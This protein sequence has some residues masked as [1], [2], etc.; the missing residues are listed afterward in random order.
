MM[1]SKRARNYRRFTQF[2]RPR[3]CGPQKRRLGSLPSDESKQA[4]ISAAAA[5]NIREVL[6][7]A[8]KVASMPDREA[9][10]RYHEL[11]DKQIGEPLAAAERFELERIEARL[12]AGDR[13]PV[14]EARDREWEADRTRLLDSIDLLLTSLKR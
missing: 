8:N 5:G 6:A 10:Q 11:V 12:D 7:V 3:S 14:I 1:A 13:D 9:A 2:S 4:P